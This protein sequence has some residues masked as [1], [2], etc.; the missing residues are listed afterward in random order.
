[1]SDRGPGI[2]DLAPPIELPDT[3]GTLHTLPMPGEATATVIVWTCNHCP[4]ARTWHD[5][6]MS[7]ARDYAPQGV[8]VLHVNSN[9]AERYP[10]DSPEEMRR[11]TEDEEW[12]GPYLHDETQEAARAWGAKVTPHV[13]VLDMDLRL[14]Y[15][16]A[17]DSDYEDPAQDAA[18]LRNALDALLTGG[19][20]EI[21]S[22]EPVGCS[23]KWRE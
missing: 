15:E 23:I 13:F 20:P 3:E 4:Y 10:A 16:G 21:A 17:P 11:R 6:L 7:V 1:M 19:K 12:P 8:R 9:D 5:R 22:T 2:G 14:R 18:W